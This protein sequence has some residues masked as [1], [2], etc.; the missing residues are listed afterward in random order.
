MGVGN[1]HIGFMPPLAYMLAKYKGYAD[2]GLVVLRNGADHYGFQFVSNAARVMMSRGFTPFFNMA[3]TAAP[4]RAQSSR[5]SW[6]M[7]S[8]AELLG[9]LMPSASI[10]EAIVFGVPDERLG[11]EVVAICDVNARTLSAAQAKA[12]RARA[13]TDYRTLYAELAAGS[14]DAVVVSTTEHTHAFATLPAKEGCVS[15]KKLTARPSLRMLASTRAADGLRERSG[16]TGRPASSTAR[17]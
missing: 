4:A 16:A 8:W 6:P 12:P 1:A 15:P 10:A 2:V 13:F 11:E 9:R 3:M 17:K 7:A 14:Y 5:F